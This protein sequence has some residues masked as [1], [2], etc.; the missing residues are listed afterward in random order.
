MN[1]VEVSK[2]MVGIYGMQV[3]AEKDASDEEILVVCNRDNPAGT[4]N[5]WG[6]VLRN[7]NLEDNNMPEKCG[8]AVCDKDSERLHFLVL[9]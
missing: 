2:C 9:C 4:T 1:R 7:E 5:G 8:P 6:L 3:C